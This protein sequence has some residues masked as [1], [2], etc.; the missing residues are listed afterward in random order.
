MELK[1]PKV[2]SICEEDKHTNQLYFDKSR[3]LVKP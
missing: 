2:F 3:M 1:C